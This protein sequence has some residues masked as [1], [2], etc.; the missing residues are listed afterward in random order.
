MNNH[1]K[2]LVA[3]LICIFSLIGLSNKV[4]AAG[5]VGLC[6]NVAIHMSKVRPDLV[7]P[8]LLASVELADGSIIC[9]VKFIHKVGS[10]HKQVA[11]TI[12]YDPKSYGFV[13]K[14]AL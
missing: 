11:Y 10:I 4:H 14:K 13:Y 1:L 8:K 2:L 6:T 5:K 7:Q 3:S 9:Y 12:N